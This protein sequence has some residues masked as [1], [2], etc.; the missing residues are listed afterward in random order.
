MHTLDHLDEE[1]AG[2]AFRDVLMLALL[3]FMALVIVLLPHLRPPGDAVETVAA[4]GNV[5]VEAHWPDDLRAD[6]DLWVQAPGDAPVGYSNMGGR[7]FNLLRDDLGDE[8]DASARNYEVS[9]SRGLAA[10][11]YTINLHLYDNKDG[12]YPVPV[13]VAVSL[14]SNPDRSA[15]RFLAKEILLVSRGQEVTAYRFRLTE[16]GEL[17]AGSVHDLPRPLR[18]A[19]GPGG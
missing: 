10:G 17:V 11:E 15:R 18:A 2:T 7:L 1:A 12:R 6:V 5:I 4:P 8:R 19:G 9:Y 14:K 3:G 16:K 13:Q